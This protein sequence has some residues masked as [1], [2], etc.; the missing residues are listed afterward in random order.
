[1]PL[2]DRGSATRWAGRLAAL[3]RRSIAQADQYE[4]SYLCFLA[5][6][7]YSSHGFAKR[8]TTPG[9]PFVASWEAHLFQRLYFIGTMGTL[10]GGTNSF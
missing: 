10:G 9:Q 8:T 4:V 6:R 1:M 3:S 2:V 7:S 5:K